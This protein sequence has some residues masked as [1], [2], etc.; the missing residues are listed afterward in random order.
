ML[1][2]DRALIY[3]ISPVF[4]RTACGDASN[5]TENH[6]EVSLF[7]VAGC[8]FAFFHKKHT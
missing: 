6:S 8:L 2:H 3:S 4:W 5:K 1:N 7:E